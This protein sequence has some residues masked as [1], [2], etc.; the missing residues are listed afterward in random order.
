MIY[1]P[2]YAY[3]ELAFTPKEREPLVLRG[4]DNGMML[5]LMPR[6]I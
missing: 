6:V 5:A 3:Q 1:S 2:E 4:T